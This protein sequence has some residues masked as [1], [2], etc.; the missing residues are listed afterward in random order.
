M[1]PSGLSCAGAEVNVMSTHLL[2]P[3]DVK[4]ALEEFYAQQRMK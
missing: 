4:N 1:M 3:K 2:S